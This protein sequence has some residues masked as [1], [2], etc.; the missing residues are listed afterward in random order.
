[1][2]SGSTDKTIKIWDQNNG[3]IIKTLLGHTESI[4]SSAVLPSGFLA[5][6]SDDNTIQIWKWKL[7]YLL[8]KI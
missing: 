3:I 6:A 4:K 7:Y 8:K 1:L 5:R 2:A